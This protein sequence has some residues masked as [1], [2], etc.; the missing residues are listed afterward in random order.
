MPGLKIVSISGSQVRLGGAGR[1]DDSRRFIADES[2]RR[3]VDFKQNNHVM[4]GSSGGIDR[5]L[6]PQTDAHLYRYP[7][8]LTPFPTSHHVLAILGFCISQRQRDHL[9]PGDAR[10]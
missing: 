9:R 2:G 10:S 3:V 5:T 8:S 1:M 4:P 6:I 7:N